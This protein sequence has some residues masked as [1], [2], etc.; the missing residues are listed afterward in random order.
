MQPT[1]ELPVE[2]HTFLT[3]DQE[4]TLARQ[5]K[6][7][8]NKACEELYSTDVARILFAYAMHEIIET[9]LDKRTQRRTKQK[10]FDNEYWYR[11][12]CT[13]QQRFRHVYVSKSG[14]NNQFAAARRINKLDI[15]H[16]LL[17][18]ILL[19]TIELYAYQDTRKYGS[20][21]LRQARAALAKAEEHYKQRKTAVD[22]FVEHNQAFVKY[23]AKY[24][25]GLGLSFGDLVGE[26]NIGILLAAE[27]F[28]EKEN[29]RF[30]TYAAWWVRHNIQKAIKEHSRNVR[31]P[32]YIHDLAPRVQDAINCYFQNT[33]TLPTLHE[34]ALIFEKPVD[35]IEKT[36]GS[37]KNEERFDVRFKSRDVGGGW[38]AGPEETEGL[39]VDDREKVRSLLEELTVG[40]REIIEER[41]GIYSPAKTIDEC[42]LRH[43][44]SSENVRRKQKRGLR[45]IASTIKREKLF[46]ELG[47]PLALPHV[48]RA[49]QPVITGENEEEHKLNFAVIAERIKNVNSLDEIMVKISEVYK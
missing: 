8:E 31:L 22:E 35:I 26:G 44:C 42:A 1:D 34:L 47:K 24:Y 15:A 18:P 41:F 13:L 5:R 21:S 30:A 40:Q 4:K 37:L 32:S 23:I 39:L 17:R 10:D 3:A 49:K 12:L 19:Q 46:P 25:R 28:D 14:K 36:I 27:R 48:G 20:Q 43:G 33:Q 9:P 2:Y 16:T 6:Y 7:S 11:K 29:T 38:F 45:T